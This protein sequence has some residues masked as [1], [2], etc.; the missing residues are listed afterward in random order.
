MKSVQF[1]LTPKSVT[2]KYDLKVPPQT[3]Q[4]QLLYYEKKANK[5]E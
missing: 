5:C 2:L 3:D 4:Y 1:P